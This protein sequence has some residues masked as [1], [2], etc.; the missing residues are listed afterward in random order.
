MNVSRLP[1]VLN[2]TNVVDTGTMMLLDFLYASLHTVILGVAIRRE[3]SNRSA[4]VFS[5][6]KNCLTLILVAN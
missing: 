3:K 6:H 1:D 4:L 5:L 2:R